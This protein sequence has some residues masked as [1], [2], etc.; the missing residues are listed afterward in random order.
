LGQKLEDANG[1][2][3]PDADLRKITTM[4][5]DFAETEVIMKGTGLEK[6]RAE[7]II[8]GAIILSEISKIFGIFKWT[9]TTY[10]LREG[11]VA[12]S[13]RRTSGLSELPDVQWHSVQSFA[14]RCGLRGSHHAHVSTLA[15]QLFDKTADSYIQQD[16]L[17]QNRSIL[18]Y[19]SYLHEVGKFIS[20]Q[21]YHKHSMYLITNSRVP[22]F[23]ERERKLMGLIA[24]FHRKRP[25]TV[26][27]PHCKNLSPK[28]LG[29]LQYLSGILRLAS[30]LDRSRKQKV[31]SLDVNNHKDQV[32][33]RAFL[34]PDTKAFV[35]RYKVEVELENIAESFG[36]PVE[37]DFVSEDSS[38]S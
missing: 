5:I 24:R 4:L 12:D 10:G 23:M 8:A 25:A 6:S 13:F 38:G 11:L 34:T 22:G 27:S 33:V 35:E 30:S 16:D 14:K 15:L 29:Y 2:E 9:I 21:Q 19:A 32:C 36:R 7:I 26:K 20:E 31:T 18:K 3:I 28:R 1:Y 17:V 37:V